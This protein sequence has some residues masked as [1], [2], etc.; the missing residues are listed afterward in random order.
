MGI[1]G[2]VSELGG[3]SSMQANVGLEKTKV[4]L[5]L[6]RE[7]KRPGLQSLKTENNISKFRPAHRLQNG[8]GEEKVNLVGGKSGQSGSEIVVPSTRQS[9]VVLGD[10]GNRK[11]LGKKR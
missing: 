8:D 11:A 3:T 9:A 2:G 1:R 4:K 7:T 6:R 10:G 5:D